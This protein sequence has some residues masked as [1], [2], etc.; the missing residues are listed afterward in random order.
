MYGPV[1]LY[2]YALQLAFSLQLLVA[3]GEKKKAFEVL[4]NC[5][6]KFP[7]R[8][9]IKRCCLISLHARLQELLFVK[10]PKVVAIQW[11]L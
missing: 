4:Q 3:L 2:T 5:D 10:W 6:E 8:I 7:Q 11:N 9:L 1:Y